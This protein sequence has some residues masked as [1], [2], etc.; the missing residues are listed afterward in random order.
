V[1]SGRMGKTVH[2][3]DWETHQPGDYDAETCFSNSLKIFSDEE[4]DMEHRARTL[5]EWARYKLKNGDREN[6]EKMWREAQGLFETLGAKMEV[7]R[8]ATLPE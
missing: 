3:S 2:F 7:E 6:G 5:R 4:N 1:I 8:M